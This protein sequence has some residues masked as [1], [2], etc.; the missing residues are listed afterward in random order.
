MGI[1]NT[2][3]GHDLSVG[4]NLYVDD[5]AS[6]VLVVTGNTA[7]SALTLGEVS[8]VASYSLDQV[9]NTGN[10]TA[11]T[12]QFSNAIT[13]LTAAS[14]VVVSGNVTAGYF[15]GD[16]SNLTGISSTLQ[17]ITDSGNVTSNTIQF[18]N[19]ITGLVTTAN[20]EVG[21]E[22]TV[23]GNVEVSGTG[24]IT[25]PSGTTAQQPTSVS[26]MVRYNTTTNNL[27][28]YDG[29]NWNTLS[30]Y[31]SVEATGGTTTDVVDSGVKYRVHTFSTVGTSNFIVTN[32]GE[33][34]YLIV[35]GG[36]GGGGRYHCGGGGGGGVLQ[37]KGFGVT[38]QTYSIVVGDGG[39]AGLATPNSSQRGSNGSNSSA[40]GQTAIGGGGGGSN[41]TLQP[42]LNGGCG[43][44]GSG[45]STNVT[46]QGGN[47]TAGQGFGGGN[48]YGSGTNTL[49]VGG[50]GGGAG[51]RGTDAVFTYN[52][53]PGY[54]GDGIPS[55]ISGT[56]EYYGGGGGGGGLADTNNMGLG[57]RGG[58]GNGAEFGIKTETAGEDGKGGGGGGSDSSS[59]G[60]GHGGSGV[61]IIR[62][63]I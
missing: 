44:G 2:D 22:L 6:N 36:G 45:S 35:A 20:V 3:P 28:F 47:G 33:V 19:A 23:S 5:D 15:V 10:V 14:N 9:V 60:V 25:L 32:G 24:A 21:G 51:T 46:N 63:R 13:S 42:G 16:G 8:I 29:T 52:A 37:H 54:G 53:A 39:A 4:S 17:A 58:G 48:G 49:R 12:V 11:N 26:G 40:F 62:Y 50:G 27:E 59:N 7:M 38:P 34:E 43:G 41:S 56:L 57:G 55:T 18:S 31:N 1:A 30:G 61:V